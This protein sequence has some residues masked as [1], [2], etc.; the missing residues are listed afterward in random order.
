MTES[1]VDLGIDGLTDIEVI[2]AGG[3]AIV[4]RADRELVD[5]DSLDSSTNGGP[6]SSD[7]ANGSDSTNGSGS[8]NGRMAHL[9]PIRFE[10]VAVKVLRLSWDPMALRRFEREQ[11]V[12]SRLSQMPGFVSI[13]ET[14]ETS[15]GSPY[16]MMP[17][18]SGGSLQDR[19]RND[20][21]MAWPRAVR[22]IEEVAETLVEAH[23]RD[24]YHRD[25]KPANIMLSETGQAHVGDFGISL[26]GDEPLGRNTVAAFTPAYSPPES[27]S[28]GL[29]PVASTD[30]YGM[31]ATLWA[32]LA[33]HAPFKEKDENVTT[34]TIFGRV[35][36]QQ[37]GDLRPRV[38]SPICHFIE[39][40]MAKLPGDRPDSMVAFLRQLR[41]AREDSYRGLERA[42]LAHRPLEIPDKPPRLAT[43]PVVDTEGS[44]LVGP[45]ATN[46]IGDSRGPDL[47]ILGTGVGRV[48]PPSHDDAPPAPPHQPTAQWDSSTRSES[49][50]GP[51][52]E[53]AYGQ[54]PGYDP[55][56]PPVSALS[57]TLTALVAAIITSALVLAGWFVFSQLTADEESTPSTSVTTVEYVDGAPRQS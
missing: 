38:P 54:G 42:R 1:I 18:Y 47:V 12:M 39:R 32:L 6:I 51:A 44:T 36:S 16:I 46:T 15:D 50:P 17:Y 53:T 10:T 43:I 9:E 21:P 40:T 49:P 7:S 20:G 33:G 13:L 26:I 5:P 24:V 48:A 31:G 19:I 30:V 55:V 25:I 35:A 52:Y 28:D 2:G 41:E 22:L 34:A 45:L 4:Y 37:I 29:R 56:R 23:Q 14:G 57:A 3:S 8:A 11:M 27:F